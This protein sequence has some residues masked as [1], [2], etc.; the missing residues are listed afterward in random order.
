MKSVLSERWLITSWWLQRWMRGAAVQNPHWKER[1]TSCFWPTMDVCLFLVI[2]SSLKLPDTVVFTKYSVVCVHFPQAWNQRSSGHLVR[3]G[4]WSTEFGSVLVLAQFLHGV[5]MLLGHRLDTGW[6]HFTSSVGLWFLVFSQVCFLIVVT[7]NG[8]FITS[9]SSAQCYLWCRWNPLQTFNL[10]ADLQ[11]RYF[12]VESSLQLLNA[13]GFT[14][15]SCLHSAAQNMLCWI[16]LST[17][18]LLHTFIQPTFLR[19]LVCLIAASCCEGDF[20]TVKGSLV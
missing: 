6:D 9:S 19:V 18:D 3:P 2:I 15:T 7:I 20:F 16:F 12:V 1:T 8:F 13:A 11:K 17:T 5:G 14:L 10:L 4:K